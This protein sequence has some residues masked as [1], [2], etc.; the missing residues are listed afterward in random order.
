LVLRRYLLAVLLLTF[1]VIT[2]SAG[3]FLNAPFSWDLV[4]PDG[5]GGVFRF[6]YIPVLVGG[7]LLATFRF[8][9]KRQNDWD[10]LIFLLMLTCGINFLVQLSG[11]LGSIWQVLYM[12]LAGLAALSFPFRLVWPLL[13]IIAFVESSNW[14][15][16]PTGDFDNLVVFL[17]LVA[18][19]ALVFSFMQRE[20]R[21]R[22]EK[23]EIELKRL[24]MGLRHLSD[25]EMD[26]GTSPL[27]EEGKRL[28]RVE[29][30]RELD[31]RLADLLSLARAATGSRRAFFLQAGETSDNF[32]LRL[33][34]TNE[35]RVRTE[36]R[37]VASSLLEQ[38]LREDRLMNLSEKDRP[39]PKLPWY[40][41][42]TRVAAVVAV[43]V[44]S[45]SGPQSVL[46]LDHDDAEHFDRHRKRL[47]ES[48]AD[49]M[50]H[51]LTSTRQLSEL[52]LQSHEFR[53]LYQASA[54]LSEA[55]RVDQILKQILA[56]CREVSRFETCSICL[57]EE[58]DDHF[59]VPVA[60]GYSPSIRESSFPLDSPNWA[61]WILRSQDRSHVNTVLRTGM[62]VLHK[63]ESLTA[64]ANF[65]GIPLHAKNRVCGT[66]LVTHRRKAF[67]PDDIRVLK[68][69]CNQA[70]VAIENARVYERLEQLAATDSLTGL[71]NRRYFHQA[72]EREVARLERRDGSMA[73]IL[74]DIDH[75]KVLNDTY[76][77]PMGDVVLKK[78]GEILRGALR[79]GDVLAR[80]GGE[81]F[82]ILLPEATYRG[83]RDFAERIRK[84][85][86]AAPLHPGGGR[87]KVTV[88]V[89][90][91]IFPEDTDSSQKLVELADR[92]LYFAKDTGRNL[93]AGYHLLRAGVEDD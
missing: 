58:G 39:L 15:N 66:L 61:G 60:E 79:K 16:Q 25:H 44:R 27:S 54:S 67:S 72:L 18:A 74:L 33:S 73:L 42:N 43:P 32:I 65:I 41:K 75:F 36:T 45:K 1:L 37:T 56:F 77:H 21:R 93:T 57:F 12:I 89:G 63:E 14:L 50:S 88:S 8:A 81:E 30:L 85:I 3:L 83:T 53:R 82:V 51:W 92:A 31:R 9:L 20:E 34:M 17:G 24:D 91:S 90:W 47:S 38:V 86:A 26:G 84:S 23:A 69:L 70:A 2:S 7:L 11:G 10:Q 55:L 78:V 5:W 68:I 19:S 28:G 4:R 49:Q 46:V 71:F 64:N 76:G 52:D 40:S 35:N 62:P 59:T 48:F 80:Y 6:L 87:R 13:G 22:V 29:Y